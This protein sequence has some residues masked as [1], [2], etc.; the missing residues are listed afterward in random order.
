MY[1]NGSQEDFAVHPV[2]T[3]NTLLTTSIALSSHFEEYTFV[4][5]FV[6]PYV[7]A[8]FSINKVTSDVTVIR[9]LVTQ[10]YKLEPAIF[11]QLLNY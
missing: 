5:L 9:G 6:E 11:G 8:M 7:S 3:I 2:L 10:L 1:C 4:K